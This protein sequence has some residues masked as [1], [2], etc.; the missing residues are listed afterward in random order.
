MEEEIQKLYD[1]SKNI[2][3]DEEEEEDNEID[4]EIINLSLRKI[5]NRLISIET[6][7]EELSKLNNEH[8]KLSNKKSFWIFILIL[9]I[10][11]SLYYSTSKI[12][13]DIY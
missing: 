8:Q 11:V 13:K 12:D 10:L 4:E 3:L 9:S 5:E 7:V 1:L 6:K 2:P